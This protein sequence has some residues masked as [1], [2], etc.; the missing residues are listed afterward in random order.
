MKTTKR[1][2][3]TGIVTYRLSNSIKTVGFDT[4]KDALDHVLRE[5]ELHPRSKKFNPFI[6]DTK[7]NKSIHFYDAMRIQ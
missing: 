4:L 3:A 7:E 2:T 1:F 6:R 5:R